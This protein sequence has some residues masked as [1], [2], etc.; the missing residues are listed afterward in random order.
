[1]DGEG[2]YRGGAGEPVEFFRNIIFQLG[3]DHRGRG[4]SRIHGV[5]C[6]NKEKL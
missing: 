3:L 6:Q 2:E 1:M 5:L 4:A